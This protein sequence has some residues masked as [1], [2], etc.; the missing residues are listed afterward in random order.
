MV[1]E[2]GVTTKPVRIS[3]AASNVQKDHLDRHRESLKR[4]WKV[5]LFKA[6]HYVD[7][8]STHVADSTPHLLAEEH[9]LILELN[10]DTHRWN[11]FRSGFQFCLN[12]LLFVLN[13]E[14]FL[15]GMPS[16]FSGTL[17]VSAEYFVILRFWGELA[18]VFN[19]P[20]HETFSTKILFSLF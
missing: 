9:I 19:L 15:G 1:I 14:V 6:S 18:R 12:F 8:L 3:Y 10:T 4:L 20:F 2:C 16:M 5:C 11:E 7:L 17:P 13:E